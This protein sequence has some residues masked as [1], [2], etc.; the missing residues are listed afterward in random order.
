MMRGIAP[1]AVAA[2]LAALVLAAPPAA[3]RAAAQE[4]RAALTADTVL[5]GDVF[6]AALRV[7]VPA[8]Y[9]AIFPD[10]LPLGPDLELA[11]R[12]RETV[13]TVPGG[14][15]VTVVY[16]LTAWRPGE[17]GLPP[18]P[19]RL[20]GP[21]GVR[22]AAASL[23]PLFVR[24]VL[25]PDTAP[26]PP[27]P[28]KDVIGADRLLWPWIAAVLAALLALAAALLLWRR[29]RA[30]AGALPPGVPASPRERA[31]AALDRARALG[32]VESGELKLFY[33]LCSEAARRY[34]AELDDAWGMDLTTSELLPRLEADLEAAD[35]AVVRGYLLSADLVKFA[36]HRPTPELALEEWRALRSW[37]EAFRWPRPAPEPV[38]AEAA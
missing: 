14:T 16:P 19:V 34:L 28:P 7:D 6:E 30:R 13:D 1:R 8:G 22:Q 5:V 27:R 20:E 36:R 12:R 3:P 33:S 37:V 24:S 29:L 11:G 10:S 38:P 23:A 9:R 15:R 26:V 25:P 4:L 17:I 18:I 32:L 21:D 31:L 35:V 2:A